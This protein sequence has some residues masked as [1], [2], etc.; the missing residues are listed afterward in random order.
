LVAE[1]RLAEMLHLKS[2]LNDNYETVS[3]ET[4]FKRC[5]DVAGAATI[6]TD[7][8]SLWITNAEDVYYGVLSGYLDAS[9]AMPFGVQ[10]GGLTLGDGVVD[11]FDIAVF[12][13]AM[14]QIPPY[15][16]DLS[17]PTVE[18]R[19]DMEAE[20]VGS[21]TRADWQATIGA[22]YCPSGR[23]L[24]ASGANG[25]SG[26]TRRRLRQRQL[27]FDDA[28]D[29]VK[30]ESWLVLQHGVWFRIA[31]EGVQQILELHLGNVWVDSA[32]GL[33]NDAHPTSAAD[34]SENQ[35]TDSDA[36]EIRWARRLEYAGA[37][38][39]ACQNIVN[40]VS[41]T[42]ALLGDTLSIRQEG[43]KTHALCAFDMFVYKPT[44]M[45]ST[46]VSDD[47][48]H[49]GHQ[50][51]QVLRGSSWRNANE[52]GSLTRHVSLEPPAA[53]A[54]PQ[55][56]RRSSQHIF[57]VMAA[58]LVPALLAVLA[59]ACFVCC[60]PRAVRCAPAPETRTLEGKEVYFKLSL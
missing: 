33:V 41:G 20:C 17:T 27:Y 32:V 2:I 6:S 38:S 19:S 12:I 15:N 46:R 11:S 5:A 31:I 29:G 47:A 43:A 58:L 49:A 9:E 50:N 1:F 59:I 37:Q 54:P 34:M 45:T 30:L 22:S 42:I 40:G 57:F 23:R 44:A 18:L 14:F 53:P 16:V 35:P 36:V 39:E 52:R 51:L 21:G 56:A 26:A 13:F 24:A 25:A 3:C 8:A 48:S 10:C 28:T 60:A 7:E 4:G 55:A